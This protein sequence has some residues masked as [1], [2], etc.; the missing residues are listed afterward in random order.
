MRRMTMGVI[1]C[2]IGMSLVAGGPV[3]ADPFR[4]PPVFASQSGLLDLV[5]IAEPRP[6]SSLASFIP[7]YTATGREAGSIVFA[8]TSL[9]AQR[10]VPLDPMSPNMAV[11]GLR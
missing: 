9:P 1:F 8:E 6:N 2:G 11:S 5:M 7:A 3:S 10:I 4:E